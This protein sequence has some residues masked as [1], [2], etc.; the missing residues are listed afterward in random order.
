MPDRHY[1]GQKAVRDQR[2]GRVFTGPS[3]QKARARM[4]KVMGRRQP[5]SEGYQTPD[6]FVTKEQMHNRS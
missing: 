4:E 2:S 6:G 1:A 5:S 3:H